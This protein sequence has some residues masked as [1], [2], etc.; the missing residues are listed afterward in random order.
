[1]RLRLASSFALAVVGALLLPAAAL[2][3]A[4]LGRTVPERGA[5]VK[6][7]PEQVAF[8]FNEPVESAFGA[9]RVY[10]SRGEQVQ[11]GDVL[12]PGDDGTGIATALQPD[13]PDGTYTATYRVVS[14]DSHPVSGGFVFS[15]GKPDSGGASIAD[16]LE[17]QEGTGGTS[18]P[19]FVVDRLLGY[20]ATALLVGGIAFLLLVWRP[21]LSASA[22]GG[23]RWEAAADALS[24]RMSKLTIGAACV[25][26]LAALAALPL[27]VSAAAGVSFTDAL[28]AD[29]IDEVLGTR[30]GTVEAL[31]ALA[32]ALLIPILALAFSRGRARLLL[33]LA[34]VPCAFLL[35][36]P[37]LAGHAST[38]D[39]TWLL[40]PLD[41]LHV[42]GMTLWLGGLAA[43]LLAVPAATSR[44]DEGERSGL[45]LA[46]L[47]RFSPLALACVAALAV[48]GTVRA[49]IEVGSFSALVDTGFGR[50]VVVKAVVLLVLIGLG[51][52]NRNRLMPAI[53]E[54]AAASQL[55]GGPGRRLRTNL[56]FEVAG[57]AVALLAASMMVGYAPPSEA[58]SGPV[59]GSE[60][61]GLNYLEYTIEPATV[62]ANEIHLYLFDSDDGSQVDPKEL[63]A[64]ASLASADVGPLDIDLRKAGPGHYVSQR[65]DFGIKGDWT[66]E[67]TV[68]TSRFDQDDVEIDVPINP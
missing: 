60:T 65:A 2:A 45:L 1:V 16:L 50:A 30:F 17:R 40:F 4:S 18:S 54:R 58:A 48:S 44:I 5:D 28:T 53:A 42:S 49:I 9:I 68:R 59:S 20:A 56:R 35:V 66:V 52:A 39:P 67:V 57:I 25:G 51:Y 6:V 21:A 36:A 33:P 64:T 10:D 15:I 47:Q 14:A 11:T 19:A 7:Q 12:R 62:G 37:A 26:L 27:Q 55:T 63:T 29:H 22:G 23:R 61:V 24:S 13:L 31:R 32:F 41:V 34:V 46:T 8:F 43:L 3:H 38:Q